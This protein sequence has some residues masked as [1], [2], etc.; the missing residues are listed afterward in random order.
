MASPWL[1]GQG[2]DMFP[3]MGVWAGWRNPQSGEPAAAFGASSA[4]IVMVVGVTAP[5]ARRRFCHSSRTLRRR[6]PWE[7]PRQLPV[8]S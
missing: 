1:A 6:Q 2:I 4:G 7:G 8:V 3:A 5:T